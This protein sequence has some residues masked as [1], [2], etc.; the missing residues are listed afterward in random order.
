MKVNSELH[1]QYLIDSISEM[2][3]F[4]CKLAV[5]MEACNNDMSYNG[6]RRV[7]FS[8]QDNIRAFKQLLLSQYGYAC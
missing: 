4:L 3:A 7:Y 6:M 2:E 8:K 1:K 5:K